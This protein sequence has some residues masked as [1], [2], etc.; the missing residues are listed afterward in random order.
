MTGIAR[1]ITSMAPRSDVSDD[2]GLG[3][4]SLRQHESPWVDDH[5]AP[6]RGFAAT[7]VA[8]DVGGYDKALVL[9]CAGTQQDF[10]VVATRVAA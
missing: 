6:I 5:R 10:P 3:V 8:D 1:L 7:V 4:G 9:D 2:A